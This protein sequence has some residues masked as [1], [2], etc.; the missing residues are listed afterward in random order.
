[1]DFTG[2][3]EQLDSGMGSSDMRSPE[4]KAILPD[5]DD[6]YEEDESLVERLV[7]LTE[8]FPKEVRNLS[9]N[10]GTCVCSCVKGLYSVSCTLTW[11]FFST[12]AILV[13][14]VLFEVERAQMDEA[15]RAQ[16]NQVLLGPNAAISSVGASGLPMAPPVQR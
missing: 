12:S 3:I 13:A 16:R 6:E 10:V 4:V 11:F 1:M 7:G 2:E 14:P 15:Q 8:M 5:D 9:Y